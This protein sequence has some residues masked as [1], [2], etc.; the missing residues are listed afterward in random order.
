MTAASGQQFTD[1]SGQV[2]LVRYMAR[3]VLENVR[4]TLASSEENEG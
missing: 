1:V 3:V 2:P 4:A